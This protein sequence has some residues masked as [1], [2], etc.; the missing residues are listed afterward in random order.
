MYWTRTKLEMS[1]KRSL[2]EKEETSQKKQKTSQKKKFPNEIFLRVKDYLSKGS[3]TDS[4]QSKDAQSKQSRTNFAKALK[5]IK[6]Y[7]EKAD[8]DVNTKFANSLLFENLTLLHQ[9]CLISGTHH[10]VKYLCE[11]PG[12][13]VNIKDDMGRT[14]L[15]FCLSQV[16]D[17]IP[18][19]DD[20]EGEEDYDELHNVMFKVNQLIKAGANLDLPFTSSDD[21]ETNR[22]FLKYLW[23]ERGIRSNDI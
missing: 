16:E 9:A 1:K 19:E 2:E 15:C 3:Q 13:D 21:F 17:I 11:Q 6:T 22:D 8:V 5:L 18:D 4:S 20:E 23:D 7:V 10:I 14:A 12:I